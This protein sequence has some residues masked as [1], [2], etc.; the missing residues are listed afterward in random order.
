LA[1]LSAAACVIVARSA[2][3]LRVSKKVVHGPGVDHVQL[4]DGSSR[5]HADSNHSF[6]VTDVHYFL[7]WVLVRG[8]DG[9]HTRC[10]EGWNPRRW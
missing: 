10:G 1:A 7:R 9:R 2:A 4:L 3:V 6:P 5:D 8:R